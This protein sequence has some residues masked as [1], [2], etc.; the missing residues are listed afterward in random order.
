M[1]FSALALTLCTAASCMSYNIDTSADDAECK[2]QLLDHS[3]AFESVWLDISSVAPLRQWLESQNIFEE[4]AAIERYSFECVAFEGM[5]L[6]RLNTLKYLVLGVDKSST[7]FRD[8]TL[9]Q[10]MPSA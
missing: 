1:S 5:A 7:T 8:T 6:N 9:G 4:P 2:G 3:K 10:C